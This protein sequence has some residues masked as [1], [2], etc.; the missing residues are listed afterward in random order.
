M[1]VMAMMVTMA[2][3]MAWGVAFGLEDAGFVCGT[4]TFECE[5]VRTAEYWQRLSGEDGVPFHL[6]KQSVSQ[7][8]LS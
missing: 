6:C 4:L 5:Q 2:M 8:S 3:I 7:S 1:M